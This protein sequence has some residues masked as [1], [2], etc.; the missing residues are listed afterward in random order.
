MSMRLATKSSSSSSWVSSSS[1]TMRARSATCRRMNSRP[2]TA[3]SR[4][5]SSG[6]SGSD[7]RMSA[8]SAASDVS[9]GS[10]RSSISRL[11]RIGARIVIWNVS[12]IWSR[13]SGVASWAQKRRTIAS[14]TQAR[15]VDPGAQVGPDGGQLRLARGVLLQDRQHQLAFA[16]EVVVQGR[17][18]PLPRE[19]VDVADRDVEAVPGEQV[20]GCP[21]QL[22]AGL[23]RVTR[24]AAKTNASALRVDPE[25]AQ[26]LGGVL[27]QLRREAIGCDRAA[28][29]VEGDRRRDL[30]Q[31][32]LRRVLH[33]L[34]EAG[35]GEV[36]VVEEV[37]DAGV[38][39]R[40]DAGRMEPGEPLVGRAL[41]EAV[42]EEVVERLQVLGAGPQRRVALVVRRARAGR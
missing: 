32:A 6:R 20:L 23:R 10:S 2:A 34:E 41:A 21:Q 3:R 35:V 33:V 15:V 25:L 7:S 16:A 40:R 31:L 9:H 42:G 38:A 1:S 29:A 28:G 19:R 5:T 4:T 11:R 27:A 39:D 8:V 13:P 12:R 17:R 18:V 24:H 30:E 14:T 36:R 37:V 22:L 26:H